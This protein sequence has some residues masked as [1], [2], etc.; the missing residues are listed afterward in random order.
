[1]VKRSTNST[2]SD[3]SSAGGSRSRGRHLRRL[4]WIAISAPIGFIGLLEYAL[5]ALGPTLNSWQGHVLLGSVLLMGALFVYGAVFTIVDQMQQELEQQ[6][7]ELESLRIAGLDV[8]SELSLDTV[9]LKVVDQACNLIGARFGALSVYDQSDALQ[10]FVTS[11]IS[12]V[13]RAQI[14]SPPVGKGLLG[15]VLKE[16]ERLRLADL[17]LDERSCGFPPHHPEMRSLLAVPVVC[18][19]PR[20]GNLY[21]S[22]K[23]DGNEFT[24]DEEQTLARFAIQAAI[25]IDNAY[26][27]LQVRNLAVVEERLRIA[28]EMHDGQAQVLAYVNTKAQAVKEFLRSDRTDDASQ[29]LEQLASAAREVYADV[30][31]GILGLR[32]ASQ[33]KDGFIATLRAH[34][35]SWKDQCGIRVVLVVKE[36]PSLRPDIELQ[37]MRIIQEALAN[38][39]KHSGASQVRVEVRTLNRGVKMVVKD[40]GVG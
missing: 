32:V 19:G 18:S 10:S 5:Y 17:Q 31:E 38:V 15:V 11:G 8:A 34:L 30:R 6:N 24:E 37:L 25:A 9:L 40:D 29:Q 39:R 36:E 3:G 20:S 14:G 2:K 33:S 12:D 1:M 21:L 35:E 27:H 16:G 26:L 28:R 22:E 13:E 23:N 4:K 7:R